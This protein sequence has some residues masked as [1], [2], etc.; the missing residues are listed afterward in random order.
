MVVGAS[1]QQTSTSTTPEVTSTSTSTTPAVTSTAPIAA[2]TT[3]IAPSSS[4]PI[5]ATTSSTDTSSASVDITT[6]Q[7]T[8]TGQATTSILGTSSSSPSSDPSTTATATGTEPQPLSSSV[9]DVNLTTTQSEPFTTLST[10]SVVQPVTSSE[11]LTSVLTV[12]S[13]LLTSYIDDVATT[14][15]RFT[16]TTTSIPSCF[17]HFLP[18]HAT[19]RSEAI[20]ATPQT[21]M[22]VL[23]TSNFTI[24][25]SFELKWSASNTGKPEPRGFVALVAEATTCTIGLYSITCNLPSR[26]NYSI[27]TSESAVLH[28]NA[29]AIQPRVAGCNPNYMLTVGVLTVQL[30]SESGNSVKGSWASS[31]SFASSAASAAVLIISDGT[32]IE[33][34]AMVVMLLGVCSDDSESVRFVKYFLS[35][36]ISINTQWAVI[37]NFLLAMVVLLAHWL[38]VVVNS[39]SSPGDSMLEVGAR[40]WFPSFPLAVASILYMG[41]ISSTFELFHSASGGTDYFA[42]ALGIIYLITVPACCLWA[43]LRIRPSYQ[44]HSEYQSRGAPAT[45]ALPRGYY[46]PE[47]P[48]RASMWVFGFAEHS[49]R[50]FAFLPHVVTIVVS[51]LVSALPSSVD[52]TVKYV[53]LCIA[54]AVA[55]IVVAVLRPYRALMTSALTVLAFV[56]LCLLCLAQ[57]VALNSSED[58]ARGAGRLKDGAIILV[59]IFVTVRMVHTLMVILI[60]VAPEQGPAEEKY[61]EVDETDAFFV[62]KGLP[63]GQHE[64]WA[65]VGKEDSTSSDAAQQATGENSLPKEHQELNK[66]AVASQPVAENVKPYNPSTTPQGVALAP[67]ATFDSPAAVDMAAEVADDPYATSSDDD[68]DAK[69]NANGVDVHALPRPKEAS[70]PSALDAYTKLITN[71]HEAKSHAS[72]SSNSE[73]DLY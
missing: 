64:V 4:A 14:T 20:Q 33:V 11:P 49:C 34:Q 35:P 31:S 38:I 44:P 41:V 8:L 52:C 13:S 65:A 27:E 42:I 72:S 18:G 62:E 55:A 56:S 54:F 39:V 7:S 10:S 21:I 68:E 25:P 45:W 40:L 59:I 51:V 61:A 70:A 50:W 15:T 73:D 26:S 53:I 57:L 5:Q 48:R 60:E 30:S 37:G 28:I 24:D 23:P 12:P 22:F 43:V 69:R 71:T 32:S 17:V 6:G 63:D 29:N 3:G 67:P 2:T 16:Q 19:I 58:T 66:M 9:S 1:T 36:F 46:Y 47:G